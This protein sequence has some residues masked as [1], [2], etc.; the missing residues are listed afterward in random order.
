MTVVSIKTKEPRE[1]DNIPHAVSSLPLASGQQDSTYVTALVE[2]T[3]EGKLATLTHVG[4][5]SFGGNLIASGSILHSMASPRNHERI[6]KME[7]NE[8]KGIRVA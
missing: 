1:Q 7:R 2:A 3:R 4:T 5:S 6:R 8:R